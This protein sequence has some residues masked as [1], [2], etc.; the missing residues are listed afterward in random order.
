MPNLSNLSNVRKLA[1]TVILIGTSSAAVMVATP[2]QALGNN[3]TGTTILGPTRERF[4]YPTKSSTGPIEVKIPAGRYSAVLGSYDEFHPS[5]ASQPSER[6]YAVF[7]G[8]AGVVGTSGITDDLPDD[9]IEI[10]TKS[11]LELRGNATSVIYYHSPG[12]FGEDSLFAN[13]I[14]LS[15]VVTTTIDPPG[16]TTIAASTTVASTTAAQ[17]TTGTT[18][19]TSTTA[20]STTAAQPLVAV[21]PAPTTI[22]VPSSV[23]QTTAI[24]TT[25]NTST[26]VSGAPITQQIVENPA[27]VSIVPAV[28]GEVI[29]PPEADAEIAFSGAQSTTTAIVAFGLTAS[30]AMLLRGS[31]RRRATQ[32]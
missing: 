3:C 16:V 11:E 19:A 30:G 13:C 8:P 18:I 29:T 2:A 20:T 4:V 17:T 7:S 12:G 28:L 1:A 25:L 32:P 23:T 27:T 9:R 6:W 21:S 14:G 22:A 24:L 10:T 15:P 5:E 31:R 26:T